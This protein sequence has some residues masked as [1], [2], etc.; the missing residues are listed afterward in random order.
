M[1]QFYAKPVDEDFNLLMKSL[2]KFMGSVDFIQEIR[3]IGGEPFMYKRIDEVI[4]KILKFSN[5]NKLVIYTNGTIVPKQD[6]VKIFQNK[7]II[8]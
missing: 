7:K 3:F 5:F 1:M 8:L 2:D 4:S 6:K